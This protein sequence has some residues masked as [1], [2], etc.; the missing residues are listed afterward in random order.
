MPLAHHDGHSIFFAHVPKTGGSSVEDYLLQRFGSLSIRQRPDQPGRKRDIIQ[1][2]SHLSA[3]D[4]Q[5]LLPD[6]LDLCFAVVRDPVRRI[7]SE[8][9]FQHGISRISR[10]GFAIWLRAV[11][12][13]ARRDPRVYEN[14]IRP[15]GDLVPE[16]AEAFKL[17]NGLEAVV[18]RIDA[19]TGQTAPQA[20]MRHL[21]QRPS[22]SVTLTQQDVALIVAFYAADYTRF[23]YAVPVSNDLSV[24]RLSWLHSILGQALGWLIVLKHRYDWV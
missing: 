16:G 6:H 14:H 3:A 10:V 22:Q 13:A 9:G 11:L 18:A 15:Q 17:E 1:S 12:A 7:T 5:S 8:Y 20:A 24:G 4:L 19:V 2:C 23:G 21:L